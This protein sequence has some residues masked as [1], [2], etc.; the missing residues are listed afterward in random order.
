M[1]PRLRPQNS[2][3][4][5][6]RELRDAARKIGRR[7]FLTLSGAAMAVAFSAHLP[8][9]AQA[10]PKPDSEGARAP[11]KD[12]FRLGVASGDPHPD[13]V[14]LW[15]R[16]APEP[17]RMDSG[18]ADEP[19]TV[20]W[21][22]AADEEFNDVVAD[23]EEVA[24]P[25]F[26]HSLHIVPE[27]LEADTAYWYRFSVG[28]WTSPVGRTRTAPAQGSEPDSLRFAF[29]SC[30]N[31]QGGYFTALRH[32]AAEEDIRAVVHLGDYIYEDAV[33]SAG[34][35]RQ[36]SE[37]RLPAE[38][39]AEIESL[40]QYR[41]RYALYHADP[42]LRSA[43]AAHPW[44][45][46]WDD[47]EVDNNY[48]NATSQDDDPQEEFLVRRAAAYRAYYEN[49]PLR[50]PQRPEEHDLRLYRR[51]RF[52]RLAQL[53]IL[54]SRQHR[55]DQSNGDGW[56]VPTDETDDPERTLLGTAQEKWLAD[57]WRQS[58]AVWNLVPQQVVLSRRYRDTQPPREVSM[59]A[60]DGYPAARERFLEAARSAEVANLVVLTGDVHVHYAMDIK[61]DFADA[62]SANLGVE[63]VTTSVSSGGDGAERPDDWDAM[64][65]ANPHMHLYD[66]R[67]GY[68]LLT[69]D[70][71]RL[72]AD[73]RTLSGV[74]QPGA[75]VST[76]ASFVSERGDP[77]LKPA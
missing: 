2:G 35:D 48:A 39:N 13:S 11:D 56:Q 8:S 1:T 36:D 65:D 23:G 45:T 7:R 19:V 54:D 14:V 3:A 26:T 77:G 9:P 27:G 63:L 12:P 37:L 55:D 29:V 28:E 53:D 40:E 18:M 61:E 5:A 16:L 4:I 24:Q 21:E 68:L 72:R 70:G 22:L 15:T 73:Y 64:R 33:D 38:H 59:D 41:L 46:T 30:Q 20:A 52:G 74:L 58:E 34:G 49:L 57:G 32:L 44:I 75:P 66:G 42:D 47:H 50:P 25:E 71:E 60:W 10:A 51:L 17:Y 6:E 69:L 67:R 43:H 62:D 31:F 76:A